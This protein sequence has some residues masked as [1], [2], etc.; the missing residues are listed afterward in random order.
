MVELVMEVEVLDGALSGAMTG[1]SEELGSSDEELG[2]SDGGRTR[3]VE[4]TAATPADDGTGGWL[5]R[6]RAEAAVPPATTTARRTRKPTNGVACRI[7]E[8]S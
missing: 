6:V 5:P 2:I 3:E 4:L 7:A 8:E 1:V